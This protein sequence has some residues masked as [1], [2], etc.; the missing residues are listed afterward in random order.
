MRDSFIIPTEVR[1]T[2]FPDPDWSISQFLTF[3]LPSSLKMAVTTVNI[4][5]FV[6][7]RLPTFTD[8]IN[9]LKTWPIPFYDLLHNIQAKAV[10]MQAR[11]IRYPHLP[12]SHPAQQLYFPLWVLTYW[13]EASLLCIHI[14][15]P[16]SRAELWCERPVFLKVLGRK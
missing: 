3:T 16:W 12:S 2:L 7:S 15:A 4:A 8:N 1:Q 13:H 14:M 9:I 6:S 11:S 10:D 5:H